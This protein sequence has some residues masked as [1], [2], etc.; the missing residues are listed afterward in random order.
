MTTICG[1]KRN[2]QIVLAW[3]TL[4][5]EYGKKCDILL[6]KGLKFRID[7]REWF[8][9]SAGNSSTCKRM[10]SLIETH[11][12]ENTLE[13]VQDVLVKELGPLLTWTEESGEVKRQ[14]STALLTDGKKLYEIDTDFS[15]F[16]MNTC[17]KGSGAD[18]AR[19]VFEALKNTKISNRLLL[20]RIYGIV[21]SIDCYTSPEFF[22][23]LG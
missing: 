2:H 8:I 21:S 20:E 11:L 9:A 18:L 5:T 1:F 6:S 15:L 23:N 12:R 17:F 10:S 19:G 22:S 13:T 4:I 16:E 3:D 7:S 14:Q